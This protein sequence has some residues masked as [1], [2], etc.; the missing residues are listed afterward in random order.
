MFKKQM[1]KPPA[2]YFAELGEQD[3]ADRS[4]EQS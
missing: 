2:R 4:L 1:G 3:A